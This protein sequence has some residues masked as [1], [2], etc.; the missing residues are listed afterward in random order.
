MNGSHLFTTHYT[1][2][3]GDLN[4]G[5]HMGFDGMLLVFHDARVRYLKTLGYT[6]FDVGG[7]KGLIMTEAR[8]RLRDE[9][10]P[11]DELA[12]RLG[13]SDVGKVRFTVAFHVSRS[14]DGRPVA[15]GETHMAGYDYSR[16]AAA[17][18]PPDFIRKISSSDTSI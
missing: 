4:Y 9:I 17:K 2:R 11:G 18:L 15:D 7:G 12:V 10:F 3:V 6:E 5:G 14:S 16:H 13:I 8:V 1:V